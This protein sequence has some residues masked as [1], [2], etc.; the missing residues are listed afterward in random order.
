MP[1]LMHSYCEYKSYNTQACSMTVGGITLKEIVCSC[2][3][4]YGSLWLI[5]KLRQG[6][7]TGSQNIWILSGQ[8]L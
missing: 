2:T 7:T 1:D 3:V 6:C 4:Q 8:A 5:A